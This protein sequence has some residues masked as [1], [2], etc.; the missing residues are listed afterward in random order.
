M[1][2][3]NYRHRS[4]GSS[5]KTS[6]S[7][8]LRPNSSPGLI[9]RVLGSFRQ[10][11]PEEKKKGKGKGKK[12]SSGKFKGDQQDWIASFQ[13]T[14]HPDRPRV[15]KRGQE[16]V[17]DEEYAA[18]I[19]RMQERSQRH[20][21]LSD[22]GQTPQSPVPNFS[23]SSMSPRS[24]RISPLA[25]SFSEPQWQPSDDRQPPKDITTTDLAVS[26]SSRMMQIYPTGSLDRGPI[27]RYSEE[28]NRRV[29]PLPGK[30][31]STTT[32]NTSTVT[33]QLSEGHS[34]SRVSDN[35]RTAA[36][37]EVSKLFNREPKPK[38]S[39][40]SNSSSPGS[41][42]APGLIL[43]SSPTSRSRFPSTVADNPLALP[44]SHS[45]S[46]SPSS[47]SSPP[48]P[49]QTCP[50]RGCHATLTTDREKKDNL[51]AACHDALCPRESAFFGPS[52]SSLRPST[53][54]V[55]DAE[56]DILHALVGVTASTEDEGEGEG[57][58]DEEKKKTNYVPVGGRSKSNGGGGGG[59][60]RQSAHFDKRFSVGNFKL[61]PAPR[62]KR[63]QI[64]EA[65]QRAGGNGGGRCSSSS[66]SSEETGNED[67]RDG[68]TWRTSLSTQPARHHHNHNHLP[69]PPPPPRPPNPQPEAFGL[70]FPFRQDTFGINPNL[71]PIPPPTQSNHND[72]A[73]YKYTTEPKQEG[74]DE[75]QEADKPAS[76]SSWTTDKRTSSL[77]NSTDDDDEDNSPVSPYSA[78]D[79]HKPRDIYPA[80]LIARIASRHHHYNHPDYQQDL[81]HPRQSSSSSS[82]SSVYRPSRD[83]LLYREIE[84]IIDC[85]AGANADADAGISVG[86]GVAEQERER[87]WE[88]FK[89]TANITPF[90]TDDPEAVEMRRKGFI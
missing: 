47:P 34:S 53:T 24:N 17:S 86:A 77:T 41:E 6:F 35:S 44:R 21:E 22:R 80:P 5:R 69:P 16:M 81:D 23:Y 79:M 48:S 3:E 84:D 39:S 33:S 4:V 29:S 8:V 15:D 83:T 54:A 59:M 26:P 56:L 25:P 60:R 88:R 30:T 52:W 10:K 32:T 76:D 75:G 1:V 78:P 38:P 45:R 19:R 63:R 51:C 73:R 71:I 66:S 62:G 70:V 72:N 65:R 89:A 18:Q 49:P 2:Q 37:I 42:L 11:S 12:T 74:E 57:G 9:S 46:R 28:S 68:L 20:Y 40:I 67:E 87:E 7:A 50:W 27:I 55:K 82:S 14:H 61:L 90:F 85:Y 31:I 58:D 13:G 36:D 64:V 43:N